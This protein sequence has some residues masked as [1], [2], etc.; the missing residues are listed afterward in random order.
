MKKTRK[1]I[2]DNLWL[3]KVC[4]RAAP[5]FVI[6]YIFEAIRNEVDRNGIGNIL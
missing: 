4:F 5:A 3:L 1:M 2:S 6:C